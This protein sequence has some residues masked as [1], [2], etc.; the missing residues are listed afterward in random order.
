MA[1]MKTL[2]FRLEKE[3]HKKLKIQLIRDEMT[4]QDWFMKQVEEYVDED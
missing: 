1:E 4:F 3:L 2:T